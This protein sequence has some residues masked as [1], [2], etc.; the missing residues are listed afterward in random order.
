MAEG[1]LKAGLS[2]PRAHRPFD[3]HQSPVCTKASRGE[4]W[5]GTVPWS[6]GTT[7][8]QTQSP[9]AE[10]GSKASSALTGQLSE[11][12]ISFSSRPSKSHSVGIQTFGRGCFALISNL[13]GF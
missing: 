6:A 12:L 5:L 7:S 3:L 10:R 11:L 9:D 2:Y 1:S 13:D 8:R 4:S